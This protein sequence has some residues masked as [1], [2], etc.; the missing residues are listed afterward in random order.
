MK[1][2]RERRERLIYRLKFLKAKQVRWERLNELLKRETD[3]RKRADL[4]RRIA[5]VERMNLVFDENGQPKKILEDQPTAMADFPPSEERKRRIRARLQ[6]R[7]RL[8]GE[9]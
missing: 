4:S 9:L 6:E 1:I 8:T 7:F 2:T 3:P 5:I